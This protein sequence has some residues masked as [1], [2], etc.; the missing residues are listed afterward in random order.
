M[1]IWGLGSSVFRMIYYADLVLRFFGVQNE[2]PRQYSYTFIITGQDANPLFFLIGWM[3]QPVGEDIDLGCC[4]GG[5]IT[6]WTAGDG[7][8][9]A[10]SAV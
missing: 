4:V 7:V 9:A 5:V 3:R 10:E 8:I 1:P 2:T 6:T